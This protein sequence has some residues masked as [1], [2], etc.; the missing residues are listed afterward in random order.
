MKNPDDQEATLTRG[1]SVTNVCGGGAAVSL[2]LFGVMIG[3]MS[4]AGSAGLRRRFWK[5]KR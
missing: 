1:F 2:S 3:L 5:K 4:L